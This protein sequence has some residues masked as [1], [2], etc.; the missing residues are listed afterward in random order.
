MTVFQDA[1][2]RSRATVARTYA[3]PWRVLPRVK[4]GQ[5]RPVVDTTRAPFEIKAHLF[6]PD[7]ADGRV[8]EVNAF[9][10]GRSPGILGDDLALT[11]WENPTGGRIRQH[12]V[13]E[14][15][16][17]APAV[18]RKF[19]ISNPPGGDATGHVRLDLQALKAREE[20]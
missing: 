19:R 7:K 16:V 17:T 20:L 1:V 3:V 9:E 10:T 8:A 6:A 18:P 14:E 11:V 5:E 4:T 13:V 15:V 2:A 12:D